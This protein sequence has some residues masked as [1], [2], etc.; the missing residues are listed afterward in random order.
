MI[1]YLRTVMRLPLRQLREVLQTLHGM[2]VS[3]GELVELLH[4]LKDYAQPVLDSLKDEIR[5]SP[6]VQADETG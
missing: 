1:A 6:A 2:A 3:V 4:R 5:A